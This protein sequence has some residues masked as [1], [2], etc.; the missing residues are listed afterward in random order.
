M[1]PIPRFV[2]LAAT[3]AALAACVPPSSPEPTPAPGPAPAPQRPAPVT[4]AP[5]PVPF[6]G[7]WMDAP[8]TAG[9]WRWRRD[10]GGSMAEFVA[11][12]GTIVMQVACTAQRQVFLSLANGGGGAMTLRT[13]TAERTLPLSPSG[14]FMRAMVEPRDP[15]LDAMAFSRGRF[16]VQSQGAAALYLPSYPEITRVV[17]DC[18]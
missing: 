7:N 15:L 14:M 4:P 17:E 5:A 6:A 18:R 13:E 11:P 1:R 8:P 12:G 2:V 10:A 9:D 3:F 16:A